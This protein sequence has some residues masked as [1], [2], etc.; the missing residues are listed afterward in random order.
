M[1][2]FEK[3]LRRLVKLF[4]LRFLGLLPIIGSRSRNDRIVTVHA[5]M[6]KSLNHR[7]ADELICSRCLNACGRS[8]LQKYVNRPTVYAECFCGGAGAVATEASDCCAVFA[9]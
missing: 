3:V 9:L 1:S 4:L 5:N 8:Q 2:V 6:N 7:F